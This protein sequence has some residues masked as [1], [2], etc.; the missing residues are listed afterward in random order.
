MSTATVPTH[1]AYTLTAQA[2]L[3]LQQAT[4]YLYRHESGARVLSLVC[5]DEEKVFG[6][7]FRTP[8]ADDTGLPHILEHSVLCGSQRFPVKEPFKDLLKTSLQT[9]LNAFTYPDRTCY[10]VASRNLKD[11][12]NL[13]DVYLDAVF[14]PRLTPAVLGQEGW[15]LI[16]REDGTPEFQGVVYNEMKGVYASADSRWE[17]LVQKALFPESPYRFDY[18]GAPDAIPGLTFEQF[19][20][21]HRSCYH[22]ANAY[23]YFYG[24]DDP[25]SRLDRLH[26]TLSRLQP[27]PV[28]PPLPLQPL[29]Q[30]TRRAEEV[31]PASEQGDEGLFVSLNWLLP[32][33][34]TDLDATL[35]AGMVSH[36][37]LRNPASPLRLALLD[38]GLGEDII[39]SGV[40]THL[41]QPYAAFGLR[42]V[43]PGDEETVLA[44]VLDSLQRIVAEGFR[45]D[46]I[47][48]AFNS[49][50][51]Y[52][53]E[54]NTGGTPRGL[55]AMLQALNVWINHG[56]PLT[57][58]RMETR[59]QALRERWQQTPDLFTRWIQEQLLDNPARVEIIVRPDTG[60]AAVEKA[61]ED[62]KL[63]AYRKE[64]A[65]NPA[66]EAEFRDLAAAVAR[67]QTQPDSPEAL[68][69]LPKLTLNDVTGFH[70]DPP[71]ATTDIAGVPVITHTIP[72]NGI[73]YFDLLLD[74]HGLP[75]S[76]LP[77]LSLYTRALSELG[78]RQLDHIRFNEQ[79][80]C[81][82][83]GLHAQIDT[84]EIFSSPD[85]Y[86]F[87]MLRAKCLQDKIPETLDLIRDM[88][89]EPRLGPPDRILQLL[90]E[91]KANEEA[92]LI[93]SGSR[94]ISL[95][96]QAAYSIA[97][98]VSEEVGGLHYLEQLRRWE[99][100][101][102]PEALSD[103]LHDLHRRL[104]RRG[105]LQLHLAGEPHTLEQALSRLPDLLAAL[106]DGPAAPA[107]TWEALTSMRAEGLIMP[108]PVNFVGLATRLA[109]PCRHGA[110]NVATRL[111]RNDFL[112]DQVRVRGGAYGASCS[113]DRLN[114]ILSF[115][116]YRDP[117]TRRT[118]DAYQ[119]SAE[120]LASLSMTD[121]ALEQ[122]K[123]G[124]LGAM[125]RT[126]HPANACYTALL[127]RLSGVT[128]E[129]RACRWEE[130]RATTLTDLHRFGEAILQALQQERRISILGGREALKDITPPLTLR[131]VMASF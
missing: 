70:A 64:F 108:S 24:D 125:S 10:P 112:W 96:M 47:E 46:L 26:Q 71:C 91:E 72:A 50:E 19:E 44:C 25:V 7:N 99:H 128:P 83:G 130:V 103:A 115:T 54:Q 127:R 118:L 121:A 65:D 119:Q 16:W 97:E 22:P 68:A 51:F 93:H 117:H 15:H 3:P 59:I 110:T 2:D 98:R 122:A 33:I 109:P 53:R 38:S 73:L 8:P 77:L 6:I 123:I 42:G 84:G 82:T 4:G 41:L 35:M 27:G 45:P 90:L 28:P 61:M 107:Q 89:Q 104:L 116:S 39:G 20:A 11:F 79:L 88:L 52:F 74:L 55:T 69:S 30:T 43:D 87:A 5:P 57:A 1:P 40:T 85:T 18:G 95:R 94:V 102:Q 34:C 111:L 92:N 76:D 21:F 37:L 78:T 13:M 106:P 101:Q 31:Y 56:D 131:E 81:H 62:E 67:F 114:G 9:F 86:A 124:T 113:Y 66:R 17:E 58:L 80:A 129:D 100:Q 23:V 29:W 75:Q 14:F 126:Q 49:T 105:H 63:A 32:G 12:H 36:L 120:W 48:G 60:R